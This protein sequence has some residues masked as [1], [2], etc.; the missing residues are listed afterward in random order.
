QLPGRGRPPRRAALAPAASLARLEALAAAQRFE[1]LRR[2][3]VADNPLLAWGAKHW[4]QNDEDGLIEEI[5]RRVR[6]DAPGA[7]LELGVGDGTENNTL[8]LLAKG[9]RGV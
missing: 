7:F 5:V 4:S 2:R 3:C 9:W 6:G 1:D 8:N